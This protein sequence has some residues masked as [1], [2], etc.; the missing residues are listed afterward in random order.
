MI[1]SNE[2]QNW[3]SPPGE[4]ILDILEER[5]WSQSELAVRTG[6][7]RKHIDQLVQGNACITEETALK[8]EQVLGSTA[9]FWLNRE[10]QYRSLIAR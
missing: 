8:L 5:G 4:T 6:Y 7:T 9:G 3:A 2:M 1:N 10:A